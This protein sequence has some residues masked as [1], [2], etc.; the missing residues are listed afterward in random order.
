MR[1]IIAR[2]EPLVREVWDRADLIARWQ[3]DG[4]TFKAEWAAAAARRA[5]S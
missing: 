1:R 2:D 5:R 3:A 4:E